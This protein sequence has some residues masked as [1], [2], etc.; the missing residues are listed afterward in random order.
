MKGCDPHEDQYRRESDYRTL[1]DAESIRG[2]RKRFAGVKKH[3][4]EVSKRHSV[5]GRALMAKGR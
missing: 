1:S 3:H 4:R 5:V 2:D